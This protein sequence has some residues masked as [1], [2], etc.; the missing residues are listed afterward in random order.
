MARASA[1]VE[2]LRNVPLFSGL[3]AKELMSLSRLMDEIDLKPGTVI[4]REGNTGGE[5]FIVIEGTIEVKR[6]GRRLARLGPGDYLGEIA[7]IDHGPRTATAM[8]ET[9]ARLLVLASREFH[10]MLASDP[11][12]ENKILRTLAAR[13]RDMSPTT[14]H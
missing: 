9:E 7:L 13:V 4:I 3:S 6:K 11:R 1:K 10:S 8:V 12:I 14:P 2:L 5:F